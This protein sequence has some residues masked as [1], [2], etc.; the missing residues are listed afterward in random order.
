[1]KHLLKEIDQGDNIRMKNEGKKCK[2]VLTINTEPRK[3][4]FFCL[5]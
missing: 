2:C 3:I 4:V 5:Y 1:M